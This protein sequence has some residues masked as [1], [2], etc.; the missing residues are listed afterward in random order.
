MFGVGPGLLL[1]HCSRAQR[2]IKYD[3]FPHA[4]GDSSSQA[5][6]TTQLESESCGTPVSPHGHPSSKDNE[7]CP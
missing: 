7:Q 4:V 5:C 1:S 6:S 2:R 3:A